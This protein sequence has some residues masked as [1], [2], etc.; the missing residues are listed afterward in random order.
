MHNLANHAEHIALLYHEHDERL[1]MAQKRADD[2]LDTLDTAVSSASNLGF[3]MPG[4]GIS[5]W[6]PYIYCPAVTV[7]AG[8]WGLPASLLRNIALI[9]IGEAIGFVVSNTADYI[10][11]TFPTYSASMMGSS[12]PNNNSLVHARGWRRH[13]DPIHD[14]QAQDNSSSVL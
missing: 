7:V 5:G 3:L 4:F 11:T 8:S 6:W 14:N 1:T 12:S 10:T 9:G 2:I 13:G